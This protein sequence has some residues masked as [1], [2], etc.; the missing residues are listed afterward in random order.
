MELFV[1]EQE[2]NLFYYNLHK[3]LQSIPTEKML[4]GLSLLLLHTPACQQEVI[5]NL[6]KPEL[7]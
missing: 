2:I 7:K 5:L 4:V 6:G 1:L 3:P